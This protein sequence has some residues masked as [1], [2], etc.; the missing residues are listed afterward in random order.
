MSTSKLVGA[1]GLGVV[2]CVV[3][4]W[5]WRRRAQRTALP[6]PLP[7]MQFGLRE[8]VQRGFL[9]TTHGDIYYQAIGQGPALLCFHGNPRSSDE[10]MD[11]ALYL[12]DRFR[13]VTVDYLGQ[14]RSGDPTTDDPCPMWVFGDYALSILDLLGITDVTVVG[15]LSGCSPALALALKHPTR[16]RR[17]VLGMPFYFFP[18]VL[19]RSKAY[20]D[21]LRN[22]APDSLGNAALGAWHNLNM[23]PLQLLTN[24]ELWLNHR[25]TLDTLRAMPF[26]WQL[27]EANHAFVESGDF[28][29]ALERLGSQPVLLIWSPNFEKLL[30]RYGFRATE[31]RA[32]VECKLKE[33][34]ADV[35]VRESRG[36]SGR[37]LG[38]AIFSED[39][40]IISQWI[41]SFHEQPVLP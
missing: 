33:G 24:E 36:P 20:K 41:T 19:E 6:M 34:G 9:P 2:S 5:L 14:G 21:T 37:G 22:R 38:E 11:I 12:K 1:F 25:K 16:V 35:V 28:E 32:L 26:Q 17:V 8:S 10:F 31:A 40:D 4:R 29:A 39:A 23:R 18:D 7:S 15:S 30:T 13:V 3:V 27:I